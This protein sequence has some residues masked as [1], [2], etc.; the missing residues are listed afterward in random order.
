VTIHTSTHQLREQAVGHPDDVREAYERILADAQVGH[1]YLETRSG[2][3]VHLVEAG[4]GRPVVLLH[5]GGTSSLSHLPLLAHLEGVRAINPDRPGF[6]LSDPVRVPRERYRDAAVEFV[7]EVLDG[8]ELESCA[9]AGASGGGLWALWYAL[10]RPERV[11]RVALLTAIPLLPGTR[12][13]VPVRV[14]VAPLIGDLLARVKPSPK[15]VV[16]FMS[17]MG[18]K[19]TI[20]RHPEV[21]ESLVAAGRDPIA[22]AAALAEHRAVASP[23][24]FRASLCVRPEELR[25]LI[26]PTLVIWGDHD[27]VGT[28]EAAQQTASLIPNAQLE[29]L[30][31]G[32]V[33]W[34]GHPER[35]AVLL[36]RFVRSD[37]E[38]VDLR[39][40]R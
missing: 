9:L 35:V 11:R 13:P 10:A 7:D 15:M 30:P 8:L 40:S 24:G 16:R 34:L 26:A 1:R 38:R 21:I 28:A 12:V 6:G 14:M 29:V 33:P 36:S 19:D 4:E 22:A 17:A 2:R 39:D 32:H 25:S 3:R 23:F 20:V 37:G 31:A 18:E 5:G 27:P